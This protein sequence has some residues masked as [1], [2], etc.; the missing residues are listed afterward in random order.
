ME[1]VKMLAM[2][3]TEPAE[4][5]CAA[6]MALVP[7]KDDSLRIHLYYSK[8]NTVNVWDSYRTRGCTDVSILSVRRPIFDFGPQEW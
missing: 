7:K 3:A 4:T 8:L 6:S 2:N 5:E 1:S